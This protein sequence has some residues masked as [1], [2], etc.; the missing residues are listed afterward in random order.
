[1]AFFDDLGKLITDAGQ[2]AVQKT[3]DM[4]DVAKLNSMITNEQNRINSCYFEI[5]KLYVALHANDFESDFA[6]VVNALKDSEQKVRELTQQIQDI[7]GIVKCER[8]GNEVPN[9]LVYCSYCGNPIPRRQGFNDYSNMNLIRCSG[10]GNMTDKTLRFCTY[11]A[12]PMTMIVQNESQPTPVQNNQQQPQAVSVPQ[13]V[14]PQAP[15]IPVPQV[16]PVVPTAVVTPIGRKCPNCG[17]AVE[18]DVVFCTECGTR[19]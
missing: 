12:K 19:I 3:K 10:C 2:S 17:V 18:D 6:V 4:T 14:Q 5:G 8:C 7:K 1:M 15:V 11:C 13:P 9:T 16:Q